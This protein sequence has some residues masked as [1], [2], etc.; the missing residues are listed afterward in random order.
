MSIKPA[1]TEVSAALL[2][3]TTNQGCRNGGSSFRIEDTTNGVTGD[4][5]SSGVNLVV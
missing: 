2:V 3:G 5:S 1:G 4:Q